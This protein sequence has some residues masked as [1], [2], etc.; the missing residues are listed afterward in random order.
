M[1]APAR[2][3]SFLLLIQFSCWSQSPDVLLHLLFHTCLWSPTYQPIGRVTLLC[4]WEMS[5]PLCST[6]GDWQGLLWTT[7]LVS[8]WEHLGTLSPQI[9]SPIFRSVFFSTLKPLLPSLW[10]STSELYPKATSTDFS[11]YTES[12]CVATFSLRLRQGIR[13]RPVY[14]QFS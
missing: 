1:L 11:I 8:C 10:P 9:T 5:M 12:I 7:F 14:S 2:L 13:Y 4:P 6:L 3:C